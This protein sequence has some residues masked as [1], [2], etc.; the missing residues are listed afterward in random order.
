MDGR[1]SGKDAARQGKC[2]HARTSLIE[3]GNVEKALKIQI[4]IG[5]VHTYIF[6]YFMY[7]F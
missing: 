3:I 5:N 6:R 4:V 7:S 2:V 1:R